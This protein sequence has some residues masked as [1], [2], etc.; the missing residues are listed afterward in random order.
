MILGPEG[1]LYIG[2][3]QPYGQLGGA[4]AVV[5]PA[6]GKVLENYRHLVPD[7][8]IVSLAFDEKS[9]LVFG[10]SSIAGGG[11][12]TPSAKEARFFAF[13][14]VRKQK[15]FEAVLE[16]GARSYPAVAAAAGRLFVAAGSRLIE[17]DPGKMEAA[18]RID[19]PGP[20]V[21]ISL[22][23]HERSRLLYGLTSSEVYA[24][25]PEAGKVVL[26]KKSPVPIRCGFAIAGEAIYFGS[27]AQLWRYRLAAAGKQ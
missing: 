16:P 10:G 14:P 9:G 12:A 4:L 21:E 5:D 23:R 26:S 6:D 27:G 24:V 22:G 19:L 18:R 1:K 15:V 17:F 25:D 8:S 20:Q 3:L 13:D 11:G 7:Q 2:S